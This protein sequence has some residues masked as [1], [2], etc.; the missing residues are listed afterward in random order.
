M[1]EDNDTQSLPLC[2]RRPPFLQVSLFVFFIRRLCSFYDHVV[3]GI[4]DYFDVPKAK[5]YV[6]GMNKR[7]ALLTSNLPEVWLRMFSQVGVAEQKRRKL[8][9]LQVHA[10]SRYTCNMFYSVR[11]LECS[12]HDDLEQSYAVKVAMEARRNGLTLDARRLAQC[13]T[14]GEALVA[15]PNLWAHLQRDINALFAFVKEKGS[16]GG[17]KR[18]VPARRLYKVDCRGPCCTGDDCVINLPLL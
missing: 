5:A 4:S 8:K 1:Q 16:S 17:R 10:E 15:H 12:L 11:F 9:Y 7:E 2:C 13:I 14:V 6:Y 3:R 18:K